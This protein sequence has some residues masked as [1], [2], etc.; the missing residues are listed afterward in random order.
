[1]FIFSMSSQVP[2][3]EKGQG[4][5]AQ[6][7]AQEEGEIP[8]ERGGYSGER[9]EFSARRSRARSHE[10][11][12]SQEARNDQNGG[13]WPEPFIEALAQAVALEAARCGGALAVGPAVV[14][15]FQI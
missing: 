6:T 5:S 2:G 12:V 9:G 11:D 3:S 1:V 8:V 13:V 10:T 4:A 15:V 7:L 14:N